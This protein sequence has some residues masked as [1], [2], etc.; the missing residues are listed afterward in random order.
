VKAPREAVQRRDFLAWEIGALS[1]RDKA[2]IAISKGKK[3]VE[4]GFLRL[5]DH[6]FAALLS[7]NG[8]FGST[9]FC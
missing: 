9:L 1:Q 4:K 3:R 2:F 5:W 8:A 7:L 6:V